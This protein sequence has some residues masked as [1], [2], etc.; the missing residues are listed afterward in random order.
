[1]E[2]VRVIEK[3]DPARMPEGAVL[4]TCSS[5]EERCLAMPL[6]WGRWRPS[7]V[8]LFHYDDPNPPRE[9]YHAQLRVHYSNSSLLEEI[10][11]T[12][13]DAVDSFRRNHLTFEVLLS[14]VRNLPV[15]LDIS[16]FTKRHLLM[17]LQWLDDSGLWPNLYIV[18][19]E[20]EEYL[21][22]PFI[23]LSFGISRVEEVPGFTAAPD[24]SRPLHVVLFLG[25]EGDRTLAT[26][27]ILQPMKTT[28]VVPDPPFQEE[29]RGRTETLNQELISVLGAA[30]IRSAHSLD[31]EDTYLLLANVLGGIDE[32]GFY[33]RVICPLG[34]KP[35]AVGAYLYSRVAI[36]PP[37][38]IYT[39]PLR[40]NHSYFSRGL[41]KTWVIYRSDRFK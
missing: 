39:G 7:R 17:L 8:V 2:G 11:F 9:I 30:A 16:T 24:T 19:S 41:G 36:D 22:T 5:H 31:P 4:L 18:Y 28:L 25:Y 40:H 10:G 21:V 1:M 15:V 33:A 34:T 3:F 12:E 35:Q 29:W 27:E 23:P 37:A 26:Y 32:R 6:R 38:L 14:E 20:P 13:R